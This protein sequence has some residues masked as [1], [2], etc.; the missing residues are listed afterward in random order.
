MKIEYLKIRNFLCIGEEPLEID[1]TKLG[2]IVLIKGRNLDFHDET[3]DALEFSSAEDEY[4]S[5]GAGKSTISEAIVY[6]LYG[7]TIRKKV[8]HQDAINKTYKKKLEVEVIFRM[9]DVRYRIVRCRKPD[10][11]SL[12]QDG[13]AWDKHNEITKGGQPSTQKYIEE[14]I[15]RMN[16]KAFVNVVCFGQHNDYNFLECTAAEQR[17]IAESL[18]S[19]EVYKQYSATAKDELKAIKTDLKDRLRDYERTTSA[20]STYELRIEQIKAQEKDWKTKCTSYIEGM[21][22]QLASLQQ[23]LDA[24]DIGPALAEYEKAQERIQSLKEIVSNAQAKQAEIENAIVT[25]QDKQTQVSIKRHDLTLELKSTD[26][27]LHDNKKAINKHQN[28][29]SNLNNLKTGAK[30]PAC[31]GT[32]DPKHYKHI[33]TLNKNKIEHLQQRNKLLEPKIIHR[34]GEVAK[35]TKSLDEL[36]ALGK[37]AIEKRDLIRNQLSQG[38]TTIQKLSNIQSPDLNS[39]ALVLKEKI[40]QAKSLLAE[41]RQAMSQ[42]GPYVEILQTATVD[43]EKAISENSDQKKKIAEV[44]DQI[45]YYEYWVKAFGDEGIRS[46]IIEGITPALNARVTYWLHYLINNKLTVQFDKHL[47]ATIEA[48][49][50]TGD[51]FA[52]F[53]TCGGERKRINLAISQAFAHV[54]MLSS[55]TWPSLVFLDEVSDS[56]DRRGIKSI[57]Q[58]ICELSAEKQVFVITHNIHLREMLEGVDTIVVER[59]GGCTKRVA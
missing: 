13:P 37:T 53:A 18:L 8:S 9:N 43:L 14:N 52:Y 2:K 29:I 36:Q 30:C 45:P 24:S 25:V 4:H 35:Y 32:I 46:F 48:N 1:F 56:I 51:P 6:G 22:V 55:G 31:Y 40:S 49:P 19:L 39:K 23:E 15:L 59:K 21:S 47:D 44:E 50:P 34:K 41:K 17:A 26:N 16:H 28:E 38:R 7:N 11:L 3:E 54:M 27:E 58:M 57:Y 10:S 42:G 33:V 20:K 12:W 5:N